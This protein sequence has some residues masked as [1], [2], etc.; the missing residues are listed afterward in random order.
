MVIKFY[1]NASAKNVRKKNLTLLTEKNLEI[2]NLLSIENPTIKVDYS[3][4]LKN[5]NYIYIPEYGRYYFAQLSASFGKHIYMECNVDVLSSF[6]DSFKNS[7][8]IAERSSSKYTERIEDSEVAVLCNPTYT[9]RRLQGQFS[10][11]N[12]G[13]NY[14]LTIGG[15]L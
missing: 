9:F 11:S 3:A 10:P 5:C 8:C 7:Q 15:N 13:T 14:L 12:N 4:N 2:P 1:N 6:Y